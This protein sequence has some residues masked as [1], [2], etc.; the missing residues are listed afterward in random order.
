MSKKIKNTKA[1][2]VETTQESQLSEVQPTVVDSTEELPTVEPVTSDT[3]AQI[4][5]PEPIPVEPEVEAETIE[6]AEPSPEAICQSPE[7]KANVVEPTEQDAEELDYDY[8]VFP[9]VTFSRPLT[10]EEVEQLKKDFDGYAE[11]YDDSRDW[12]NVT[13]LKVPDEPDGDL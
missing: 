1:G 4:P 13:E 7:T 5:T 8:S 12:L 2:S 10:R 9:S 6:A 3:D 11:N